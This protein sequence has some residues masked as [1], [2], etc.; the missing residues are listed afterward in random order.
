MINRK[1]QPVICIKHRITAAFR[2]ADV[3]AD[4][5]KPLCRRAYSGFRLRGVTADF[6][7]LGCEKMRHAGGIIPHMKKTQQV[8]CIKHRITAAFLEL[9][10]GFEPTTR[11]LRYRCSAVEPHQHCTEQSYTLLL[12]FS[13][14]K[15]K[16]DRKRYIVLLSN[17]LK[18]WLKTC[19]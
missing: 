8:N 17:L 15:Q 1:P 6:F 11:G 5:T 19:E 10:T 13:T 18:I 16:N 7:A 12:C 14:K 4:A 3:F 9:V 2:K